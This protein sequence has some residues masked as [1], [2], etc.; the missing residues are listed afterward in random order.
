M[1]KGSFVTLLL[2]TAAVGVAAVFAMQRRDADAIGPATGP[3]F[4][5]LTDRV[6]D[7]ASLKVATAQGQVTVRR[8]G[9]TWHVDERDGYP[10]RFET[11]KSVLLGVADLKTLEPKTTRPELYGKLGLAE[12][13]DEGS[14]ATQLTLLDGGGNALA[15]VLVGH[16]G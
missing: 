5:G 9:E 12:P 2:V 6:N 4:P 14:D 10:A 15:S 16:M 8:D 11:V 1:R 7:V 13:T 3:L